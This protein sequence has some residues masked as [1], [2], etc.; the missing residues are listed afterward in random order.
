MLQRT[1]KI[2]IGKDINRTAA[3]TDAIGSDHLTL[4]NHIAEGEI[5][6]LDKFKRVL[7]AGSTIADTDVIYICQGTANTFDYQPES[8]SAVSSAVKIRISDPIEG[9]KVKSYAGKSYAAAA[10]QV[11]TFDCT[12]VT[13]VVGTEYILRVVYKDIWE[14]PGQ[15]T[16]TYRYVSTTATLGTFLDNFV[17]KINA[18]KGRRVLASTNSSTTLVLTGL[19]IPECTTSLNDLDKFT[20]V[21]FK[22]IL[23]YVCVAAVGSYPI[24]SWIPV[25]YTSYTLTTKASKGSGMWEEVRDAER[26]AWG[27]QGITNRTH[28]PIIV[29]D[30]ATV[31][32]ATYDIITIEHDASYLSPDNQYVKQAPLTTQIAFVVPSSGTQENSVLAVLN[33][34]FESCP[35]SFSAISV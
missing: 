19:A 17:A 3:I 2:F 33:P 6:V 16:H 23:N 34:W 30:L 15:F 31:K 7:A 32:S 28:F 4:A 14:H 22:P 29:P 1:N 27:Y 18:H 8:G 5:V 26:E 10:Q 24:G 35:K 12:G 21:E 13:P 9:A 11:S 20:V 25:A